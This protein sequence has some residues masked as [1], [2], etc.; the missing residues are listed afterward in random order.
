M[1]LSLRKLD[2]GDVPTLERLVVENIDGLEPGL[3]VVDSRLLLGHSTIDVV[4]QDAHGSLVLVALGA[5][6]DEGMLLRIVD[7]YSWCL[8]YAD[9]VRRYFPAVTLS[10]ERPPRVVFVA[11]RVPE[12]FHRKV[13]QLN[14]PAIDLIEFRLLEINGVP[15]AYF[16]PIARI[17]RG[18]GAVA[19][20]VPDLS[21]RPRVEPAVT[22]PPVHGAPRRNGHSPSVARPYPIDV[23]SAPVAV[24]EPPPVSVRVVAPAPAVAPRAAAAPAPPRGMAEHSVRVEMPAPAPTVREVI[25]PAPVEAAE[26][27]DV[28]EV[29]APDGETGET[30][31]APVET[32]TAA[33]QP[34]VAPLETMPEE[35]AV[36]VSSGA[37]EPAP[38]VAAPAAARSE[39]PAETA[40]QKYL[41]SE[42]ARATQIAKD[43]GIE[44]PKDGMLTRQWV[45]FLNQL[46]AK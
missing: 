2:V 24:M 10:E 6:A 11:E 25:E 7:A 41:F 36:G 12:S 22:M 8:E 37:P 39:T 17:R 32:V 45:D 30:P 20:S 21:A 42:A 4:A 13:K 3:Q 31:P 40:E 46:A 35:P 38:V 1:K 29:A 44:L 23:A 15:A 27:A 19:E 9:S 26:K 43:F 33:A 16:D 28:L 34:I 14:V 18:I 5:K